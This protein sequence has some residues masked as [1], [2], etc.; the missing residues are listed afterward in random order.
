MAKAE[1]YET[2]RE[3]IF[4]SYANLAMAHTAVERNQEKYGTFNFVIIRRYL[5]LVFKYCSENDLLEKLVK[6]VKEMDLPFKIE[7]IPT[8]Y[9]NPSELKLNIENE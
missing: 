5:K 9:P 2:V 8:N 6:E 1:K 3:L 4:W 7:F